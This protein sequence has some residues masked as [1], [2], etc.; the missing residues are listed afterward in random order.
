MHDRSTIERL[1]TKFLETGSVVN[2]NKRHSGRPL[3]AKTLNNFQNLRERLDE[4]PRKLTH[5]LSQ[6]VGIL[7]SSG[8]SFLLNVLNIFPYIIQI[9]QRQTE[10]KKAERLAFCQDISQS[11]EN[12]TMA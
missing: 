6:D 4:S 2:V 12:N 1:V 9:L 8:L 3:S 5:L 11:I 7:R 10:G